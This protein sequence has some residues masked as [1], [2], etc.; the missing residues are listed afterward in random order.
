MVTR[1]E[2]VFDLYMRWREQAARLFDENQL[3]TIEQLKRVALNTSLLRRDNADPLVN[4][5]SKPL[6]MIRALVDTDNAQG[7][8]KLP[9]SFMFTPVLENGTWPAPTR[10]SEPPATA[11]FTQPLPPK[12]M[13]KPKPET[14]TEPEPAPAPQPETKTE[15]RP[16]MP[17]KPEPEPAPQP[18][19]AASDL[20]DYLFTDFARLG[21][22][23][24]PEPIGVVKAHHKD[25]AVWLEWSVPK[26]EAG[27]VRLF[28]VISEEE[29]FERN[30]NDGEQRCVTVAT[31]WV[32]RDP[33]GTA[34]RMYQIW[35]HTGTSELT[36]LKSE[37]VLVGEDAVIM[38]VEDLELSVVG[39]EIRGLWS[40]KQ[41]TH[42][43]AVYQ[44]TE[45]DR[46]L[47]K[48]KNEIETGK[49]NLQG[50]RITPKQ[51]GLTYK[52]LVQR[53]V[54]FRDAIVSSQPSAEQTIEVPAEVTDVGI[55]VT[56]RDIGNDV[57]FDVSWESTSSGEVRL[58]RTQQAPED[59]L[60]G[61]VLD[62]ETLEEYGLSQRDWA[63]DLER[64]EDHCSVVW[65][66]D[67]FTIYL[68][69]VSVVGEKCMVGQSYSQVRVGKVTNE[70]IRERVINQLVTFGWPR[71]AHEVTA[72][73][74]QPP[75]REQLSAIDQATYQAEGGMRLQLRVPGDIYLV[76]SVHHCGEIVWGEESKL[77]YRGVKR[78]AYRIDFSNG[79]PFIVLYSERPEQQA[80]SFTL[81]W[82]PERLPLEVG[83]GIEV[84]TRKYS[85]QGV[86]RDF[87]QGVHASQLL[88]D[89]TP[90]YWEI[91]G[92]FLRSR[93]GGFL[94]LFSNQQF[95]T[96]DM[97]IS[98]EDPAV[99]SLM[100]SN[101]VRNMQPQS[102]DGGR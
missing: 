88:P 101:L 34:L 69:P 52:F 18:V 13:P 89:Q 1:A 46:V 12:P 30:P 10:E 74:G 93:G 79:K 20:R 49:P 51:R 68:T 97:A 9:E 59:G 17:P 14:N 90:E 82:R 80:R 31:K 26:P 29:E 78:F 73:L 48:P 91:D 36:A 71:N 94:R 92:E 102:A 85:E 95:D 63:N 5:W 28:R 43:V 21:L 11:E 84:R 67:W 56:R 24:D 60:S 39:G 50:F 83:D 8:D 23:T 64:G 99:T 35:M 53:Q 7:F 55:T 2:V 45:R 19:P 32:D 42:R 41:G 100:V 47:L 44:A 70:M 54:K 81:R 98:L 27:E 3:P 40:P 4:V 57:H 22:F 61:K 15:P 62:V 87:L 38:P 86:D 72:F 6:T 58:Y 76:P 66:V 16:E 96:D 65:P 37:P 33:L 75:H 77:H 25:N